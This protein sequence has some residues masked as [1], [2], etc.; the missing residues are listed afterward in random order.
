MIRNDDKQATHPWPKHPSDMPLIHGSVKRISITRPE[1]D[2][3]RDAINALA[4]AGIPPDGLAEFVEQRKHYAT[5]LLLADTQEYHDDCDVS[6]Y[7][8]WQVSTPDGPRRT[9]ASLAGGWWAYEGSKDTGQWQLIPL[10][11][12]LKLFDAWEKEQG[13]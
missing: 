11:D 3:A 7:D 5:R 9:M 12:W 4:A 8:L 10:A 2:R 1:Y 13:K 6:S